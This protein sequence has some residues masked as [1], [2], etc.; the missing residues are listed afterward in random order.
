[1]NLESSPKIIMNPGPEFHAAARIWQGIP[2]LERASNGR[3]WATWYTGEQGEGPN[4]HVVVVT[5]EDDGHTWTEP[6]M[7]ILPATREERCY[8]ACLWVDPLGRLWLFWAQSEMRPEHCDGHAGVWA[9]RTTDGTGPSPQWSEPCRLCDGV[10]MNKP[11]VLSTGEWLL[12][13]AVWSLQKQAVPN[14][15]YPQLS[16]VLCSED[17]GGTWTLRGSADVPDRTFDEHMLVER[18]DGSLWM[19]VRT[20]YGVGESVSFDRG[21]TWAPG[22]PTNITGPCSRFFIRRLR[23]GNLLLVNHLSSTPGVRA[24]LAA[25]LSKDDGATWQSTSLMLDERTGVSYPDGVEAPDGRIYI[26]YDH[27]R[28]DRRYSVGTEEREILMA[29]FTERDI[30]AGRPVDSRTRLRVTVNKLL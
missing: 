4:N 25:K 30:E 26:I 9:I 2:G 17:Q 27:N 7:A 21:R 20:T 19:L 23:S 11:T 15:A 12:P 24:N 13:V 18:Q 16:N 3:L 1:V 14:P 29:V 28:G 10:M 6:V 22:R 8:D 5:S